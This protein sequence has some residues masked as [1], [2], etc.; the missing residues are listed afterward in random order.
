MCV[1]VLAVLVAYRSSQASDQNHT[2]E[3]TKGPAVQCQILTCCATREFS[4]VSHS[5]TPYDIGSHRLCTLGRFYTSFP[6]FCLGTFHLFSKWSAEVWISMP[7]TF[8]WRLQSIRVYDTFNWMLFLWPKKRKNICNLWQLVQQ[9]NRHPYILN[10]SEISMRTLTNQ[11]LLDYWLYWF[12]EQSTWSFL[13]FQGL[14]LS[15][16]V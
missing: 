2:T 7:I 8:S 10:R 13:I 5:S 12:Q 3:V 6:L 14:D 11:G 15:S 16:A 9:S 4:F 1:C